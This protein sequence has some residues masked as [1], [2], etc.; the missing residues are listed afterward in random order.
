MLKKIAFAATLLGALAAGQAQA[1]NVTYTW[2]SDASMT[3]SDGK[4]VT[5]SGSFVW[6]TSTNDKIFSDS[7]T[8]A[9]VD[10][11]GGS[12]A[13]S[14]NSLSSTPTYFID[15]NADG[16]NF[17]VAFA[18]D[19]GNGATDALVTVDN[20][21]DASGF[22]N[23]TTSTT[24]T[25]TAVTGEACAGTCGDA[26]DTPEPASMAILGAGLAGLGWVRRRRAV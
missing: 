17:N 4:I 2:S 16:D 11:P 19:L 5:L 21:N 8:V 1:Q 26:T 9:G 13:F 22:T 20:S 15:L 10:V 24:Y 12:E 14:G 6:D 7:T 18:N 3:L 23:N 25:V